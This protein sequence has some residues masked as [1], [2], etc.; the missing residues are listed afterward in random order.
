MSFISDECLKIHIENVILDTY[1]DS[2]KSVDLKKFN[3]NIIDPIEL[4]FDS[5][6]FQKSIEETILLEIDRQRDKKIII[7]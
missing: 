5:K 4:L 1:K 2:F 7:L 3:N 6:F